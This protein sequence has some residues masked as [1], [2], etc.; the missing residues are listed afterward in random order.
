MA[1]PS[2]I[3]QPLTGSP[4]EHLI[5]TSRLLYKNGGGGAILSP[6]CIESPPGE[7]HSLGF[8]SLVSFRKHWVPF[9]HLNHCLLIGEDFAQNCKQMDNGGLVV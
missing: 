4:R 5:T 3:E 2:W 8:P 9:N 7:F 6:N 1:Y